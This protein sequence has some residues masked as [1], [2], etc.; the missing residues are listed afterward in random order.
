MRSNLTFSFHKIWVLE[1]LPIGDLKTGRNLYENHIK[2]A[3]ING[4]QIPSEYVVVNTTLELFETLKR[5]KTEADN[6]TWP[7]LHIECHGEEKGLHLSNGDFVAWEALKHYLIEINKSTKFNLLI[8]LAACKG[9]WIIHTANSLNV[10]SPFWGVV[11]PI[12]D[13]KAGELQTDLD[14]F[15]GTLFLSGDINAAFDSLDKDSEAKNKYNFSSAEA[16]FITAYRKYYKSQCVGKAKHQRVEALLSTARQVYGDRV[17]VKDARNHIKRSL[18]NG[19]FWFNK[20]KRS[21][22]LVNIYPENEQRFKLTF[23]HVT[24]SK[25]LP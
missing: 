16:L 12:N 21:F 13:I 25:T 9:A 5:I 24:S 18:S 8:F 3:Q 11:A 17:S 10:P 14:N 15:Y 19:A 20:Y 6:F 1:S 22:F 23:H 4:R 2:S 7:L